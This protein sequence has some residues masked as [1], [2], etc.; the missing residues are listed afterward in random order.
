MGKIAGARSGQSRGKIGVN[1]GAKIG[2]EV[3]AAKR[4]GAIESIGKGVIRREPASRS[5]VSK[6][7][8]DLDWI[9][10]RIKRPEGG[11]PGTSRQADV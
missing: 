7:E 8:T 1:F 3:A 11:W 4:S 5:T 6:D 2:A 10:N 9:K